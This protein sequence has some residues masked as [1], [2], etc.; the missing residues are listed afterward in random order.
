MAD[1]LVQ[2][3]Q[4]RTDTNGGVSLWDPNTQLWPTILVLAVAVITAILS[5]IVLIAYFWGV[6]AADRWDQRRST[7]TNTISVIKVAM[8]AVAA[9][10]MFQTGNASNSK[11]IFGQTCS[12][13]ADAKQ[14]L[15][16]QIS[17][18]SV[19]LMQVCHPENIS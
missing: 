11:T 12:P 4:T 14:S 3:F 10:T 8:A 7:F 19:C 18:S 15:F 16:P 5:A 1:N 13:A 9:I 17:F 2:Y 6:A